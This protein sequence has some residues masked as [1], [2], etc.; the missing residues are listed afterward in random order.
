MRGKAIE[1]QNREMTLARWPFTARQPA[2]SLSF[3]PTLSACLW[4][5]VSLPNICPR[6]PVSSVSVRSKL[7]QP[8]RLL[9]L[10]SGAI[11]RGKCAATTYTCHTYCMPYSSAGGSS[12]SVICC[13]AISPRDRPIPNLEDQIAPAPALHACCLCAAG[14]SQ[15]APIC[16]SGKWRPSTIERD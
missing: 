6:L 7:Y 8:E 4:A 12:A 5:L 1:R 2:L 15:T 9:L 14:T 13:V 3:S 11:T 16:L 10:R